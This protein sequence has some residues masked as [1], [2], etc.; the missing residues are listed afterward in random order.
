[1]SVSEASTQVNEKMIAG[2][3]SCS[4][5]RM[6]VCHETYIRLIRPNVRPNNEKTDLKIYKANDKFTQAK[7]KM[8]SVGTTKPNFAREETS[9]EVPITKPKPRII[10]D[11]KIPAFVNMLAKGKQRYKYLPKGTHFK[12]KDEEYVPTPIP[13]DPINQIVYVPTPMNVDENLHDVFARLEGDHLS[14]NRDDIYEC[15]VSSFRDWVAAIEM[16]NL[17]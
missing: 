11:I 6:I 1:M 8:R 3:S 14:V 10:S 2:N 17:F 7:I 16:R 5:T 15:D 4:V 13:N 12:V 9:I